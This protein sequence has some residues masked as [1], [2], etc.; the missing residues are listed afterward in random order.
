MYVLSLD[1]ERASAQKAFASATAPCMKQALCQNLTNLSQRFSF[2][3]LNMKNK[4]YC[5]LNWQMVSSLHHS[6]RSRAK[7][8]S[9]TS[10]RY[11][12]QI[13]SVFLNADNRF[14][15]LLVQRLWFLILK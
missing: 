12:P 15:K 4:L 14:R 8:H 3:H 5:S 13:E 2:V 6:G 10:L 11:F 7:T 9:K 1:E